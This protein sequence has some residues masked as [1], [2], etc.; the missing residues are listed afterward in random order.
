MTKVNGSHCSSRCMGLELCPFFDCSGLSPIP[1]PAI[2]KSFGFCWWRGALPALQPWVSLWWPPPEL[3]CAQ[4]RVLQ[5]QQRGSQVTSLSLPRST[6]MIHPLMIH[7]TVTSAL[8]CW[9][10]QPFWSVCSY[11]G[12][13][14]AD[15]VP[16]LGL[17]PWLTF[18]VV[19]AQSLAGW[20]PTCVFFQLECQLGVCRDCAQW[21]QHWAPGPNPC[22]RDICWVT[23]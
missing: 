23:K 4:Q 6:A 21:A 15:P 14:G 8:T 5:Q 12:L 1:I 17:F 22:P 7:G 10:L 3:L 2:R 11:T 19:S 16:A 20:R 9:S 13:E 18:L